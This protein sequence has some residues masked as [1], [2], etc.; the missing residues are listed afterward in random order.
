MVLGKRFA[1]NHVQAGVAGARQVRW[2]RPLLT[3]STTCTSW[4]INRNN[5][6][7][8]KPQEKGKATTKVKKPAPKEATVEDCPSK[9]GNASRTAQRVAP[10]AALRSICRP[11]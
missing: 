6:V 4:G 1:V 7:L 10:Q 8:S 11:P 9:S 3:P 2:A 5:D